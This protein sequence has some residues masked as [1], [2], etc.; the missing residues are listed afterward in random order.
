M[1]A[2]D[3]IEHKELAP[4]SE[5]RSPGSL[6][7]MTIPGFLKSSNRHERCQGGSFIDMER[8]LHETPPPP[9]LNEIPLSARLNGFTCFYRLSPAEKASAR[10][11]WADLQGESLSIPVWARTRSS[12]LPLTTRRYNLVVRIRRRFALDLLLDGD[13]VVSLTIGTTT[14]QGLNHG[15]DSQG[16][17]RLEGR[18]AIPVV[19]F[20]FDHRPE[21]QFQTDCSQS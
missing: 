2:Q 8:P 9:Q 14:L 15:C 21:L 11:A 5:H 20:S 18:G 19:A 4:A 1:N 16:G 7:K 3:V 12:G 6:W 10:K 13:A 17:S